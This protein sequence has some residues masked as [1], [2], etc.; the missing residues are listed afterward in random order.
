MDKAVKKYIARRN[1]RMKKR[2][3]AG[4]EENKHPRGEN[5]QFT[6]G[7][8]SSGGKGLAKK[9]EEV[10]KAFASGKNPWGFLADAVVGSH[11]EYGVDGEAKKDK[12][13]WKI[14][15]EFDKWYPADE[16]DI[17]DDF[18]ESNAGNEGKLSAPVLSGKWKKRGG[19]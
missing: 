2:L 17:I 19:R 1:E 15:G 4:W 11:I 7:S 18:E 12:D 5:G 10:S 13:G 16:S 3:D 14:K 6:S 8:S 9:N